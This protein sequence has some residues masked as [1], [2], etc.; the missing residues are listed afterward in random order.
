MDTDGVDNV[1][2]CGKKVLYY[3]NDVEK[4]EDRVQRKGWKGSFT[5]EAAVVVSVSFLVLGTLL[6]TIFFLHDKAVFQGMVC[7]IAAAGSNFAMKTERSE[8][9]E[10]VRREVCNNRFLGSR[11]ISA[12]KETGEN[13]VSVSAAAEYPVPGMFMRFLRDGKLQITCTWDSQVIYPG[14]T[15]RQIRGAELLFHMEDK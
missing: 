6:L 11:N 9:A 12:E 4:E 8:K 15:I 14:K 10:A 7:E 5:A 2:I 13:N 1:L 3:A